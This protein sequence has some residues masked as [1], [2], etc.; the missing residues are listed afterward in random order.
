MNWERVQENWPGVSQRAQQRWGKLTDADVVA[1]QDQR[2]QLVRRIQQRYGVHGDEA[3]RQVSNWE[4]K[5]T[6]VWFAPARTEQ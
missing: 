3:N 6:E 5:A 4:R 2:E 1:V